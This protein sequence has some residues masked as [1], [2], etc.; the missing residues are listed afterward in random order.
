MG[1]DKV[2]ILPPDFFPAVHNDR[3]QQADVDIVG[4]L[5]VD[6]HVGNLEIHSAVAGR[7]VLQVGR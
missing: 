6:G 2:G 7:P 4:G 1:E 3:N 5:D